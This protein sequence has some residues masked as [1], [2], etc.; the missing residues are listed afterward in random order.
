[1]MLG[2]GFGEWMNDWIPILANWKY[3]YKPNINK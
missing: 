3:E 1:M 2:F